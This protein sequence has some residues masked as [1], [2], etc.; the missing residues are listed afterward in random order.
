M[1][2]SSRLPISALSTK[3]EVPTAPSVTLAAAVVA[4]K[5][6]VVPSQAV[7]GAALLSGP[8][9]DFPGVQAGD[10]FSL[11]RG[12][13][14]GKFGSVGGAGKILRFDND[15]ASF[16]V[17]AGKFGINVEAQVDVD[18][19]DDERVR[20]NTTTKSLFPI[21]E[22]LKQLFGSEMTARIVASRAN[23]AEFVNEADPSMTMKLQRDNAGV[24]TIDATMPSV[25][26]THLILEPKR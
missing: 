18:R 9:V 21:P 2:I 5:V 3:V 12:S 8:I 15:A 17:K 1:I 19:I 25:G 23:Y 6:S 16:W 10:Q 7:Q 13:K 22:E 14:A 24:I 4:P 20:I 26:D 11:A